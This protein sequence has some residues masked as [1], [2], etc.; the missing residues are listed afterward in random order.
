M[1]RARGRLEDRVVYGDIR[2]V[3]IRRVDDQRGR[4]ER[5]QSVV[6]LHPRQP[7]IDAFQDSHVGFS[8]VERRVKRW[9]NGQQSDFGSRQPVGRRR[10]VRPSVGSGS[11]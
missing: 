9:R 6:D 8:G 2:G 4:E 1:I 11:N 3:R 7:A 10:P 5:S